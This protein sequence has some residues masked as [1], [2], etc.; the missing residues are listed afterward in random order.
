MLPVRPEP[1]QVALAQPA[2]LV[3]LARLAPAR[4]VRV[5]LARLVPARAVR[6]RLAPARL[7]PEERIPLVVAAR[8]RLAPVAQAAQVAPVR[9]VVALLARLAEPRLAALVQA[10]RLAA[11]VARPTVALALPLEPPLAARVALVRRLRLPAALALRARLAATPM[12]RQGRELALALA[13]AAARRNGYLG[14]REF[15]DATIR[16]PGAARPPGS[17]LRAGCEMRSW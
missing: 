16:N 14:S 15:S 5:R 1:A 3:G 4:A 11:L 2:A 13:D 9:L 12:P 7:E 10:A 8:A 6:V 17:F